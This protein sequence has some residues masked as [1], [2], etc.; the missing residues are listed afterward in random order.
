MPQQTAAAG[1]SQQSRWACVAAGSAGL[2]HKYSEARV[3]GAG[4]EGIALAK[5]MAKVTR[6]ECSISRYCRTLSGWREQSSGWF[7]VVMQPE[8]TEPR[9]LSK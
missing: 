6:S 7:C 9:G 4:M 5:R 3:K 8:L 2:S 1:L